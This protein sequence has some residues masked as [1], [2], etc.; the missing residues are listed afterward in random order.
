MVDSTTEQQQQ[1]GRLSLSGHS[2]Q[3]HWQF[4]RVPVE[5][6]ARAEVLQ[7]LAE[8]CAL[9]L[10]QAPELQQQARLLVAAVK[11]ALA[12]SPAQAAAALQLFMLVLHHTSAAHVRT[13][14]LQEVSV[15]AASAGPPWS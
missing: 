2:Q 6:A 4:K 5:R 11:K 12:A 14:L 9:V 15:G 8:C 1:P 10:Q 7:S 13:T 3:H